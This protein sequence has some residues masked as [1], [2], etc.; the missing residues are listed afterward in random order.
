V[1]Q[2]GQCGPAA[3]SGAVGSF[4]GPLVNTLPF[5]AALVANAALGGAAS[6]AAGGRFD[7]GAITAAFG[8]LFNHVGHMLV[9]TDAHFQLLRYLEGRDGPGVWSGNSPLDGLFGGGRPDL[10]YNSAPYQVYEIKPVGS[11]AAGAAQLQGYLDSPGAN[12]IV[13]DFDNV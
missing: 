7:N 3:L 8:Y 2:G 9:G 4:A 13:G 12:G 11:E 6:V 5:Q 1:A 10:I